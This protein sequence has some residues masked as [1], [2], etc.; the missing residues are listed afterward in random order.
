LSVEKQRTLYSAEAYGLGCFL[1][2][3]SNEMYVYIKE[4]DILRMKGYGGS[5]E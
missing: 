2:N 5:Y 3:F 1:W 4:N